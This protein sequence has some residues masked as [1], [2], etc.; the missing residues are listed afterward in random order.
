MDDQQFHREQVTRFH[1]VASRLEQW[2]SEPGNEVLAALAEA[3]R[4]LSQRPEALQDEGPAMVY[5][6]F[7]TSPGFAESFPRDLLWYLGAD[8]LHFM[9]DDE[10][11]RWTALDEERREAASRG[12]TFDWSSAA[13]SVS[14]LQ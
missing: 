2:A 8:C 9:P 12:Q 13:S 1:T 6:L 5:R 3:F 11:E 10:I 4:D 14:I 7:T